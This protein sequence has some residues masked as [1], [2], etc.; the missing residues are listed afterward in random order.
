M[1]PHPTDTNIRGKDGNYALDVSET[2]SPKLKSKPEINIVKKLDRGPTRPLGSYP[3]ELAE[4]T[5]AREK[6]AEHRH[7]PFVP[8]RVRQPVII[9]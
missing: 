4:R 8:S 7:R 2:S 5:P 1:G 9:A 6:Q 3:S